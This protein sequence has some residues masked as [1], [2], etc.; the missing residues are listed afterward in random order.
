MTGPFPE[1]PSRVV[2]GAGDVPIAVFS[3]GSGP[4][5]VLV[6]GTTADHTAWR[7]VAPL[8]ART[9]TLHAIDRRGRGASGDGPATAAQGY[10]L[11]L[12]YAD[13]AAV[14]DVV[15]PESGSAVDVV[16][17][18]YGGRCALGAAELTTNVRRVVCYEGAPAPHGRQFERSE[19]VDE[20][21]RRLEAG[22][23]DAV[24]ETFM[25]RVTGMDDAAIAAYRAN[26]VWPARVAAAH[27][28][29]RELVA[30]RLDPPERFEGLPTPVLFIAGTTSPPVFREGA[31]ALA[32][33]LP[34]AHLVTVEG[35][36]HAAH[37]THPDAFVEAVE[38]F[39]RD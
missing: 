23:P 30:A 2:P 34:D 16:G 6:H 28:V 32:A 27:T 38:T 15:A 26:P 17:H 37:H 11:D 7:T 39:L 19:L 1:A 35:A 22:D 5:L 13:V 20:L 24:M 10:G 33:L 31:A 21:V 3:L 36:A 4:P 14:V 18:S 9:H 8:L 29:P 12:E 25:R